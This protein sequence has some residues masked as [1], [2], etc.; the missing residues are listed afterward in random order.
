MLVVPL[1]ISAQQTITVTGT[2]TDTQDEPMIGVNIT[3]K[4]VAGFGE[5]ITDIN[6]NFFYKDGTLSSTSLLIHRI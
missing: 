6:G 3:V 1:T 5:P 4:D 2:V